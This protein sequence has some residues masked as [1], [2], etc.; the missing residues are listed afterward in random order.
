MD[1]NYVYLICCAEVHER[2]LSGCLR[3]CMTKGV[4]EEYGED[5]AVQQYIERVQQVDKTL[6]TGCCNRVH[7]PLK[8]M[9]VEPVSAVA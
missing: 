3:L 1:G 2:L 8:R 4:S 7:S 6:S 5:M 9:L